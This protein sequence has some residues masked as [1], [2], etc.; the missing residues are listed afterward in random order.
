MTAAARE[1]PGR[2]GRAPAEGRVADAGA[3]VVLFDLD[4][5]LIN[6]RR[7]YMACYR[8]AVLPYV[9]RELTQEEI[10]ALRPR[11]ELRFL[12]DVV[13]EERLAACM[14]DFYRAYAELHDE[15]FRGIY[16]GVPE[17]LATLRTA[18]ARLGIVTG[19]SR[20]SWELTRAREA[21]GRFD[22][23][24]FDDDVIEPKPDPEGLRLA[25]DRLGADPG[26]A[27][28]VG[29]SASDLEAA[30]AA[31]V[32]P[33]AALWAKGEDDREAFLRRIASFDAPAFPTPAAV[34]RHLGL[35]AADAGAAGG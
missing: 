34:I 30:A 13:G 22:V 21:L 32:R 16:D 8:R 29:D 17:M 28:Y 19:K 35:A 23:L 24:V 1:E 9:G 14:E 31:G 5:T 11:S 20:R 10:L 18:R 4:G 7:L 3:L 15:Y 12:R 33:A 6:T 2:A 25:L 26:A 27:F